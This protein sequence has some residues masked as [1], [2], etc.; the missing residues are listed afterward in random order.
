LENAHIFLVTLATVLCVAGIITVV[1]LKL[2]MPVIFGYLVA[3]MVVASG[4]LPAPI[5]V[6]ANIVRTLSEL[7]VILLMFSLGLEFSL[8]KLARVA[9]MAGV[10][11]VIECSLM[12]WLGYETGRLF[13]WSPLESFYAGAIVSI[14]STS[15]IIKA[16]QE[17]RCAGRFTEIVFGILVVEDLIAILLLAV[18]TT[19]STGIAVSP[20]DLA[21]EGGRLA[22]FLVALLVAGMLLVPR[23]MRA[24]TRFDRPET[25]L[26]AGVGICFASALLA[27][28]FGYS[29]A[30]GA[31]ISGSLV[32]ESGAAARLRHLVE[33]VRDMFAAVFFVS[34]GM[35]ID[36]AL[37][38]RYWPAVLAFTLLVVAGKVT[39]VTLG[40]FIMGNGVRTSIQTGMSL[41]Q[42]GEF[43]FIIAALGLNTG[44]TD[45]YLFPVAVTVSAATTLL[46]PWLIRGSG[47][48]ATQ[49]DRRL[50]RALRTFAALHGSWSEQLQSGQQDDSTRGQVRRRIRRLA[51]DLGVL[52][53][54]VLAA[55][56]V[57][58]Q[59][60]QMAVTRLGLPGEPSRWLFLALV[61]L[62]CSPFL[63]GVV[64][65][66]HFLG[67]ALAARAMPEADAGK[68]DM[69]AAPRRS[70]V[71]TLQLAIVLLIALPVLA[72]AQP[73][74]PGYHGAM[75]LM[76]TLLVLG[77]VFW[78][79][80]ANLDGHV[81][82]VSQVIVEVLA[83]QARG[84]GGSGGMTGDFARLRELLPGLGLTIPFRVEA[85]HFAA[86]R[87]M[88]EINIGSLTGATVLVLLRKEKGSVVPTG[89]DTVYP[90]DLLALAG[91]PE[92]VEAARRLLVSGPPPA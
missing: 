35:L 75:A 84:A 36:P 78:R 51:L 87:K 18:L 61:L 39:G 3:G 88:A 6:D 10:I 74:I 31:F 54:L 4:V 40:T 55:S 44:A 91:T 14:S 59:A 80:A 81:Q 68:V 24:V 79:S 76:A 33:P 49:V 69:A 23:F 45:D 41:C 65:C 90:G 11:A 28:S 70:L 82:A 20:E 5:S 16:F 58:R 46:T 72:V 42:I 67:E 17:M 73:F 1:S 30:L 38:V 12:L 66:I 47:S 21:R 52:F 86:G 77:I 48:V 9:P 63:Y 15:I 2:K 89:K 22:L 60:V 85:D 34:I 26:V 92:A 19:V 29:V 8:N 13:G 71:V 25:T 57:H 56:M 62:A 32:A 53:S 83:K 37:V 27:S 7:G 43:S 64:R 50:P